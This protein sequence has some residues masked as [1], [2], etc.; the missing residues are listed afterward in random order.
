MSPGVPAPDRDSCHHAPSLDATGGSSPTLPG[1][2]SVPCWPVCREGGEKSEGQ[3]GRAGL[4]TQGRKAAGDRA[5]WDLAMALSAC[6]IVS[7]TSLTKPKFR[8]KIKHLN[9][10]HGA[11]FDHWLNACGAHPVESFAFLKQQHNKSQQDPVWPTSQ[12]IR[13]KSKNKQMGPNET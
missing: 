6:L 8:Y 3:W 4:R 9:P 1:L 12:D 11:L 10:K 7:S 13:N 5:V 2:N